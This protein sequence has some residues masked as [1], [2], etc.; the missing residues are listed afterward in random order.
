MNIFV[1]DYDL[2]KCAEYHCD[3]HLIKMIL[4]SSQMLSTACRLNGLDAGYKSTHKNHPCSIWVRESLDN[5]LWLRDLVFA[6]NREYK[7]RYETERDH[8]SFSVVKSLPLPN[9]PK[10]GL[11]P[12]RLAMPDEY[13]TDDAVSAYRE[14]YNKDKRHLFSWKKR[15][16]PFWIKV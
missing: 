8:K 10:L 11:T 9:I 15:S 7:Y 6:L 1:L 16:I 4:E 12:F 5:W 13:K 2:T 14:Y 3:K